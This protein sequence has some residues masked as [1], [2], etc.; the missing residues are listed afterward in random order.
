M[1]TESDVGRLMYRLQ[2]L[3]ERAP[4][5]D[6]ARHRACVRGMRAALDAVAEGLP[7]EGMRDVLAAEIMLPVPKRTQAEREKLTAPAGATTIQHK[8]IER[9]NAGHRTGA[10]MEELRVTKRM[11]YAARQLCREADNVDEQD[12]DSD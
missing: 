11:I 7:L 12:A 10:I 5:V 1:L 6:R 8:I 9:L 3:A 2:R 4:E